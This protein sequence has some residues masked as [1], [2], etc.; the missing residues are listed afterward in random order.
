MD[1]KKKKRKE[2]NR[3]RTQQF[4]LRL[5]DEEM[6]LLEQKAK[7]FNLSRS[8][9]LR[10]MSV[11]GRAKTQSRLTDEQFRLLIKEL[12]KIGIN[13]NQI[14]R[15]VNETRNASREDFDL[16]EFQYECLF[17]LYKQWAKY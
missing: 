1:T 11:W 9:Y 17:D 6:E 14:A 8:D 12:N 10:S 16:L 3:D 15:R 5:L 7:S 2:S 13:I 4:H